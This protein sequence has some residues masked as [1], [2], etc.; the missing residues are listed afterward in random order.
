ML[1]NEVLDLIQTDIYNSYNKF[2]PRKK[3]I[4]SNTNKKTAIQSMDLADTSNLKS[5]PDKSQ[6]RLYSTKINNKS[7]TVNPTV[8]STSPDK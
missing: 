8:I 3:I 1:N 6:N 5:S 4:S 2:K 7:N